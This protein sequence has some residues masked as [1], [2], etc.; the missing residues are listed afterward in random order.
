ME[1]AVERRSRDTD[2]DGEI[3]TEE[4]GDGSGPLDVGRY[5]R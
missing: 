3:Y 1:G 4:E 5:P 2:R